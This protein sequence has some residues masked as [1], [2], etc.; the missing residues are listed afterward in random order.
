VRGYEEKC[1]S[2]RKDLQGLGVASDGRATTAG[3]QS[4]LAQQEQIEVLTVSFQKVNQNQ[5]RANL[6]GA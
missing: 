2:I 5:Q 3:V 1:R 6:E 4:K